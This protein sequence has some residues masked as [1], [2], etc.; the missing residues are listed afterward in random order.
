MSAAP[1]VPRP[2]E[3]GFYALVALGGVLPALLAGSAVVGDGVDLYGT[4]WFFWWIRDS[5]E[6]LRDPS[7]TQLFFF[8]LGKDIFAHTGNN[9]L[10]AVLSL[11]FQ[12][13]L[14]F[15]RYQ[16]VFV[17]GVLFV[18]ALAFRP[19]AARA[20]GAPGSWHRLVLGRDRL[21]TGAFLGTA[22]WQ[23]CSFTLFEVTCGRITQAFLWF[24]PL[25]VDRLL[26]LCTPEGRPRDALLAGLWVGLQ[27]MTYWFMGYFAAL[28]G[29]WLLFLGLVPGTTARGPGRLR[30]LG[31]H[32][33]AAVFALVVVSPFVLAM[34]LH[35]E[36]GQVPG[37]SPDNDPLMALPRALGNN[38]AAQLHGYL[39][40][41][42]WGAPMLGYVTWIGVMILVTLIGPNRVR[43]I[44]GTAVV[45]LFAIGPVLSFSD[46]RQV[47]MPHYLVAYHLVPFLDRFWFPYR[48]VVLAF[49]LL[50]AGA[51]GAFD[52][53]FA[54]WAARPGRI[55]RTALRGGATTVALV[56]A[57]LH[58]AEQHWNLEW[59]FVTR[60][61]APPQMVRWIGQ[62]TGAVIDL[63]LGINKHTIIWQTVHEQPTFGGMGENATVFWP[64]GYS[65]RLSIDFVRFLRDAVRQPE[66][67][68]APATDA[69]RARLV[70]EGFRWVLLHRDFLPA[71][72]P[73]NAR[74]E[75]PTLP[76]RVQ[77]RIAEVLGPPVAVDGPI[78]AWDLV[79][80]AEPPEGIRPTPERLEARGWADPDAPAYEKMLKARG[81]L[82]E[83]GVPRDRDHRPGGR[84]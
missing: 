13:I 8:P 20:A 24:L 11:P 57:G 42:R 34:F 33:L 84:P 73:G 28:L 1:T 63:P 4:L 53:I 83:G 15:P 52:R 37:L 16:P 7:F 68:Q 67:A 76:F 19:L 60:D 10:D 38:V 3:L 45:L 29:A 74:D 30:L 26:A 43:W 50:S 23:A 64:E 65:Q 12:W 72:R 81:R 27:A 21:T 71:V 9:F 6:H 55:G 51:A 14:G 49:L 62:E 82:P 44:G 40:M 47:P 78:V 69:G 41:E 48:L 59:P 25:A 77:A 18:N 75:D 22:L 79:G 61:V 39:L 58:L 35:A 5:V 17:A 70:R 54:A 56:L 32:A 66:E 36:G 31:R 46:G 80:G 2:V